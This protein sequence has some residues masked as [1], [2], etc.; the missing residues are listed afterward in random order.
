MIAGATSTPLLGLGAR[1]IAR[2][3]GSLDP[4]V[5]WIHPVTGT[6]IDVVRGE[7][8]L[9]GRRPEDVPGRLVELGNRIVA[10][11][12]CDVHVH[13][14][15][16][17]QANGGSAA[18]V[19]GSLR[20][21]AAF[22]VRHGTTSLLATTVSDSPER[23]LAAVAGAARV[24][25][26]AGRGRARVL[27]SHLEGPFIAAARAGAQDPQYIRRPDRAE[28]ERLL[29]AGEGTVMLVTLAPELDGADGVIAA[30]LEAGVVVALGHTDCD[31][32][33][34][35]RTFDAGARHVTHLFDAMA[36][37]HH[38]R[39]GLVAA[40]LV[41]DRVTLELICDFHH[42][43]AGAIALVA[44]HAPGRIA[45]VT[46]ATAATGLANGRHM[47]GDFEI[48]VEGT[49]VS[50]ASDP[51]TLAGSV[52]TMDHAVRNVV[53]AAGMPLADALAAASTVPA[54]LACSKG[55]A[56][57]QERAGTIAPGAPADLVVLDAT[58]E[59]AATLVAGSV[60]FDPGG[61]LA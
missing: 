41:D 32:D 28:L 49:R 14:A 46:D 4:G 6:I 48:V 13:G 9:A 30:C 53:T 44:H 8:G 34:A 45:L 35:R 26:R 22:H 11:G 50:L 58:L 23:L 10:P 21:I 56:Q 52:L 47:L 3:D 17:R 42:V 18:E 29:E 31:Y 15:A 60:A 54:G 20:A 19:E 27:G 36:P 55:G 59:V 25:E 37:F 57:R 1:R 51:G 2:P 39:P 33:T 38:R 43:H 5:V 61:L 16:G 12:F 40:A 24:T 7:A